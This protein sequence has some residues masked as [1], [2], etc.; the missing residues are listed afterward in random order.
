M[1][2]LPFACGDCEFEIRPGHGCVSHVSVVCCLGDLC[3]VR[4]LAQ[5]SPTD[6]VFLN[7]CDVEASTMKKLRAASSIRT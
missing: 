7:G 4:T 6:C 1:D 5:T 2:L 3:E